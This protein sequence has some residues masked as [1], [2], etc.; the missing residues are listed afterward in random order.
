MKYENTWSIPLKDGY[1]MAW[2]RCE[3]L[4]SIRCPEGLYQASLLDDPEI[5]QFLLDRGVR[6]FVNSGQF[7]SVFTLD[8][9][10]VKPFSNKDIDKLKKLLKADGRSNGWKEL[11]NALTN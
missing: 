10:P 4:F 7:T 11:K 5:E 8:A 3:D 6:L 1:R 2:L 9:M